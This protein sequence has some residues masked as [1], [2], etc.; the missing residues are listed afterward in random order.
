[1]T[2]VT[3]H[4]LTEAITD[5]NVN[6]K[7][8]GW[9][10][11]LNNGEIGDLA[12]GHYTFLSG[13]EVQDEVNQNDQLIVPSTTVTPTSLAAPTVTASAVNSTTA[14]VSWNAVSGAA[15]TTTFTG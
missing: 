15:R 1:M 7:T 2:V 4:E 9:Y 14:T 13:F 11:S 3:S 6:Y 8:L 10:D 12:E 5:P